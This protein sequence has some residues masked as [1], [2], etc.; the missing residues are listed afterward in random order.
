MRLLINISQTISAIR[1]I[2]FVGY[3][4]KIFNLI[5]IIEIDGKMEGERKRSVVKSIVWRVICI[6]VSILTTFFLTAR[7]D[8][9]VAIG[10]VYNAV[11]MVLYY[12]HE[13]F[14]N[15]IGWGM[16][17]ISTK[18]LLVNPF[19]NDRNLEATDVLEGE[20]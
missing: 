14:W 11:T 20:S 19:H 10:T 6:V 7:W 4:R 15:R 17:K 2:F 9:A 18:E 12:F 1:Y 8:L 13:R 5:N 3:F 16:K